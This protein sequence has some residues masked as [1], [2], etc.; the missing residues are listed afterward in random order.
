MLFVSP[1]KAAAVAREGIAALA[2]LVNEDGRF[3]YRFYLK[4]AKN[5]GN[6]YSAIRHAAA[7]WLMLKV[8]RELGPVPEVKSA[9]LRAGNAM[10]DNFICPFSGPDKLSMLEE[11][12][13]RIGGNALAIL[14]LLEMTKA[15][16]QAS[17][18]DLA[19]RLA[20]Y[21]LDQRTSDGDF[22]HV[23]NY[24]IGTVHPFRSDYYTGEV[25]YAL[26]RLYERTGVPSYWSTALHSLSTLSE[27]DYGVTQDSHWMLYALDLLESCSAGSGLIPYAARIADHII[28]NKMYRRRQ[29]ST[30]IACRT[31]G[32]LA[33]IRAAERANVHDLHPPISEAKKNVRQNLSLLLRY[34]DASGVF[35]RGS[36]NDEVQIDY[37]QH[38]VASFAEYALMSEDHASLQPQGGLSVKVATT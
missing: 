8:D 36:D 25:L 31:E 3:R 32:L 30:P 33:Y 28:N 20:S 2:R 12:Y 16:E 4:R 19:Q 38:A 11:G 26:L 29:E 14:A 18:V 34:R 7:V 23:R 10:I 27:R 21:I 13:Y 35:M 1:L 6:S 9:A 5:P 22:V 17:Y 15:T 37:V 24:P